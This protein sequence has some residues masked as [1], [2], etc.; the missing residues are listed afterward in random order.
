MNSVDKAA[1]GFAEVARYTLD[2]PVGEGALW[3]EDRSTAWRM[4]DGN[5]AK[6]KKKASVFGGSGKD[7]EISLEE[8]ARIAAVLGLIVP[9]RDVEDMSMQTDAGA[10]FKY[11]GP[12]NERNKAHGRGTARYENGDVFNGD[13]YDGTRHGVGTYCYAKSGNA[14]VGEYDRGTTVRVGARWSSTRARGGTPS[15][16]SSTMAPREKASTNMT[17]SRTSGLTCHT[18]IM[19]PSMCTPTPLLT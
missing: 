8:A 1:D 9:T 6:K 2:K 10:S 19:C 7:E 14:E 15:R 16:P 11:D 3:N 12:V 18:S 4:K 17:T 13:F 5:I